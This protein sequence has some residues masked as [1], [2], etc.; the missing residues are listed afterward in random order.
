[1][2][3]KILV[4]LGMESCTFDQHLSGEMFNHLAI[5]YEYQDGK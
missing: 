1:M 3:D 2:A 5:G 4:P